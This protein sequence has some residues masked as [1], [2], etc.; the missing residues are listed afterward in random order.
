MVF[1]AADEYTIK[2]NSSCKDNYGRYDTLS[3][4]KIKCSE[5][6][7]CSMVLDRYNKGSF[8]LCDRGASIRPSSGSRIHVKKG[9]Y[10]NGCKKFY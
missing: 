2:K 4:A 1:F 9:K 7:F 5:N 8:A 6:P 3:G 10:N